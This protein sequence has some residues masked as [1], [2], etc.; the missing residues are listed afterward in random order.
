MAMVIATG[1]CQQPVPVMLDLVQPALAFRPRGMGSTIWNGGARSRPA[2]PLGEE[3]NS[4]G[5]IIAKWVAGGRLAKPSRRLAQRLL[6]PA[7]PP[8]RSPPALIGE[9]GGQLAPLLGLGIEAGLR[10]IEPPAKVVNHG[11]LVG[12][13]LAQLTNRIV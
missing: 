8:R 6:R 7:P 4:A 13:P 11:I 1:N 12:E 9:H 5:R 3:R 10:R 2:L